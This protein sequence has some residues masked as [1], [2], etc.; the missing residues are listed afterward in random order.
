MMIIIQMIQS[1]QDERAAA[2]RAA[3]CR[4]QR[5]RHEAR[6]RRP[7]R[8]EPRC[9]QRRAVRTPRRDEEGA[10]AGAARRPDLRV[11]RREVREV[12]RD[13]LLR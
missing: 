2:R 10:D 12:E 7:A 6:R 8:A 3:R 5:L 1:I 11:A 9:P 13:R 4:R